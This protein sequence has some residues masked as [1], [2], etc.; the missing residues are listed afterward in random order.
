MSEIEM[1]LGELDAALE[2]AT[3]EKPCG[4]GEG[5]FEDAGLEL[6]M[7]G[8]LDVADVEAELEAALEGSLSAEE[9]LEFAAVEEERAL[10]LEELLAVAQRYPG[11]RITLSFSD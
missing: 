4:C 10:T 6:G 8:A 7:E 3:R 11:L 2:E 9:E 5:A 1:E